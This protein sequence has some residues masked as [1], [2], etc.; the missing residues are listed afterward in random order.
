MVVI[1]LSQNL[2][3]ALIVAKRTF[4]KDLFKSLGS[5]QQTTVLKNKAYLEQNVAST[6]TGCVL[7]YACLIHKVFKFLY[8]NI[9]A[10]SNI[11]N[12]SIPIVRI[13]YICQAFW[14]V[15]GVILLLYFAI[16]YFGTYAFQYT[17]IR[18]HTCTGT[19]TLT[20]TYATTHT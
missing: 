20:P 8:N 18:A 19:G 11:Q 14:N 1:R 9:I 2:V 16:Y 3:S 5:R 12:L 10:Y 4:R 15:S 13:L 7:Q 17:L 6:T